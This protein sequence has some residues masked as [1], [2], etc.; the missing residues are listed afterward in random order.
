MIKLDWRG[1][2]IAAV[3]IPVATLSMLAAVPLSVNAFA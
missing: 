3:V 2:R 1:R